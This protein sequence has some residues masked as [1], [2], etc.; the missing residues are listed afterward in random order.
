MRWPRSIRWI[1]S[2][3][4]TLI[5]HQI[6]ED[7]LQTGA[8]PAGAPAQLLESAP[9]VLVI[10]G[11][12]DSLVF[13]EEGRTFVRALEEK[14]QQPVLYLEMDG[15]QHAFD[16]FHS[17]RSAYA[18]RAATAFLEKIRAQSEARRGTVG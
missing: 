5:R 13:A 12:H 10:Q 11:S 8:G 3:G 2:R 4:A 16:P 9:P 18:V 15:A 7:V 6:E 17:V 1:G 14:S